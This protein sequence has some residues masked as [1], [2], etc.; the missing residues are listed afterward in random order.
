LFLICSLNQKYYYVNS[1]KF[2]FVLAQLGVAAV[3]ESLDANIIIYKGIIH[4]FR[5]TIYKNAKLIF[6]RNLRTN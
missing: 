5:R 6:A 4:F 3:R 2:L 1:L